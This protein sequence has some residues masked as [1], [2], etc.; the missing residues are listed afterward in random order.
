MFCLR[1]GQAGGGHKKTPGEIPR[2]VVR[3]QRPGLDQVHTDDQIIADHLP[4][5]VGGGFV[6]AVRD[7]GP[8]RAAVKF[9]GVV[10]VPEFA[11]QV[12]DFPGSGAEFGPQVAD[13][14]RLRFNVGEKVLHRG[15]GGEAYSIVK[16]QRRQSRAA[17]RECGQ[18]VALSLYLVDIHFELRDGAGAESG[19]GKFGAAR[20]VGF[21]FR[22]DGPEQVGGVCV[23][24]VDHGVVFLMVSGVIARPDSRIS[25][26]T[27]Q[28]HNKRR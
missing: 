28:R 25:A 11:A 26:H 7:L 3:G 2:G 10:N 21:Q 12:A 27:M 23:V 13:V 18:V 5:G 9:P 17:V 1:G 4:G 24:F 16:R 6:H 19:D 20:L 14:A 22:C 8:D 15:M